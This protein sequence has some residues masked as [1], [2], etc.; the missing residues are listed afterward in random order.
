MM[1]LWLEL[2]RPSAAAAALP[3]PWACHS[4]LGRSSV[5]TWTACVRGKTYLSKKLRQI[6]L[7]LLSFHSLSSHCCDKKK[8]KTKLEVKMCFAHFLFLLLNISFKYPFSNLMLCLCM[9]IESSIKIIF[10]K[11]LIYITSWYPSEDARRHFSVSSFAPSRFE[12]CR[13][14]HFPYHH[15]SSFLCLPLKQSSSLPPCTPVWLS[16]FLPFSLIE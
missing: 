2:D 7:L 5:D 8:K 1:C 6:L 15:F 13:S 3:P 12:S 14:P 16:L 9:F 4:R 10:L 11:A